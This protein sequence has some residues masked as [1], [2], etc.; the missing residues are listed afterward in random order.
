V[1][2]PLGVAITPD[3]SR[4][5]VT[6]ALGFSLSVIDTASNTVTA[7]VAVGAI[8]F[9]LAVTP[10]GTRAYVANGADGTVSVIV[11]ASNSVVATVQLAAGSGPFGVAITPRSWSSNQQKSVQEGRLA[12]VYDSREISEPR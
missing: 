6:N 3:G 8:P 1:V 7:T 5:D 4:A 11:M 12:S 9:W 10:D 2:A